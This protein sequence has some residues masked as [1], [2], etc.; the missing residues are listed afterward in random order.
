MAQ[1]RSDRAVPSDPSQSGCRMRK[2]RLSIVF[3]SLFIV[4]VCATI[5]CYWSAEPA[6]ADT[7]NE[8][9][10]VEPEESARPATPTPSAA[11][12]RPEAAEPAGSQIVA[13]VNIQRILRDDL[14][15]QCRRFHGVE[16]LE[17]MVNRYLITE[18][19]RRQN[20][21]VTKAEV[22]AEIE[23][24]AKRFNIP[25]EQYVKMLKQERNIT[26]DQYAKDIIWPTLALRKIAGERLKI[27]RDELVKE[28]EI[29]YGEA[30]R[31]RLIA[32]SSLE[33]AKK[34]QAQASAKPED[35]GNLAKDYSEDAPSASS[36]GVIN[37]IRKHGSYKQIEEAVFNMADGEVSPVIQAG[38]QYVILKREGLLPARQVAFE[39]VA[40]R[41]EETLRDRKMRSVAQDV[42][43]ELQ[44]DAKVEN[45]WNDAAKRAKMP[46]VA[47]TINGQPITIRELDDECIARHGQE[48]LDGM[49]SRTILEQACKKRHVTVTD[50]DV[51]AEIAR[52]A[53]AGI[54]PK[55]DGSPDIQSWLELVTKKQGIP[56]EVYRSDVVWPSVALK[57][58]VGD[59][60]KV[61]DEDLR[62]GYEANYGARVRCLAIVLDNQRRAQQVFEMARKKNT[63]EYF[64]ELAAQY[65][66]EPGSQAMH[67]E[68]PPIKKHGGQPRL[69]EEAFQLKP[70]E[71]SGVI[72]VAD[73]FI[74]LRCEGY[75]KAANVDF[76]SVRNEIRDDL[77]EKKLRLAMGDC[78]ESLKESATVDN[79]LNGTSH[80]PKR[81]GD[82][83]SPTVRA[84]T[85]RQVPGGG[86]RSARRQ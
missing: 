84:P 55:A 69:E 58:L 67:G 41:L 82:G 53:L 48:T 56:L 10:A 52:A 6:V 72:Q 50:A 8:D 38:G 45:V 80:A 63:A 64:G 86:T 57:K 19:C 12:K 28:F 23:R 51:N 61:T 27:G 44:K 2:N 83:D 70:G 26:P 32:V 34:L 31:A 59:N 7:S 74:I 43:Q 76:G 68:V 71:L 47:A 75:T 29:Q 5:R 1:D 62:M 13:T 18:E 25:V 17:S 42:F 49:I 78:F 73:K 16:V 39:Q 4:A 65:S 24:M 35:F 66:I 11:A 3:G 30:V 77:H 85:L 22:S 54:K 60:V 36:K 20:I 14:A 46:G 15:R 33:K 81:Q 37:P 9:A 21:T 79:Y 40:P